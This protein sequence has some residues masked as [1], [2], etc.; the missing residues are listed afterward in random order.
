MLL[1]PESKGTARIGVKM[2]AKWLQEYPFAAKEEMDRMQA[3]TP[4]IGLL[5]KSCLPTPLARLRKTQEHLNPRSWI[6]SR[7][8]WILQAA[9][10]PVAE[11]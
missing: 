8:S 5:I 3:A 9:P 1:G 4:E 11:R 6:L 10:I 7:C 2:Y